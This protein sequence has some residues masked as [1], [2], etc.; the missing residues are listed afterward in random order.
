[1][2]VHRLRFVP[3]NVEAIN[4]LAFSENGKLA[5]SRADGSLELWNPMKNW[6]QEV[7]IRADKNSSIESL[8]WYENRL[9]TAGLNGLIQEWD[10][11]KQK[12]ISV[13]ESFGIPVWCLAVDHVQGLLAA[14][15]ED[16]SVKLYSV[17]NGG[18]T[19]V[20]TLSKQEGR[21]MSIAWSKSG[22]Y[23]ATGGADSTI[24]RY[25]LKSGSCE[26]RITLDEHQHSKDTVVWDLKCL[27]DNCIV[28]AL[29]TG[30]LQIYDGKLGTLKQSFELCAADILTVA[31]SANEKTLFASGIDQK[32]VK[33][34][35]VSA[36]KQFAVSE[37]ALVHTHDVRALAISS[38]GQLV[39]GGI[40][41]QL[42][43]Y[44]QE[45][46]GVKKFATIYPP[47]SQHH[48]HYQLVKNILI[49]QQPRYL[50]FWKLQEVPESID[51]KFSPCHPT[52]HYLLQL[53]TTDDHV[54]C[55]TVS[56]N[57]KLCA[58]ATIS[59]VWIYELFL[60]NA[61]VVS[62][63]RLDYKACKMTFVFQDK[64]I[65]CSMEGTIDIAEGSGY[66]EWSC[67]MKGTKC[68]LPYLISTS[69]DG[70]RVALTYTNQS[71]F[72]I[73]PNEN[74]PIKNIPKLPSVVTAIDF[75]NNNI[76]LCCASHEI[77]SYD[78]L[79]DQLRQ[80]INTNASSPLR[81]PIIGIF[82]TRTPKS[83][84]VLYSHYNI[85][86]V[87][88]QIFQQVKPSKT[89]TKRKLEVQ[90]QFSSF[91]WADLS[92]HSPIK[93]DH[94]LYA[95]VMETEGDL[96]VVEKPWEDIL[97]SLPPAL[98]RHKYGVS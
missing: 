95:S 93:C 55:F 85:I 58:V 54:R 4:C 24:R 12:P 60:D 82:F 27:S 7:V 94:V 63:T 86:L 10:T 72:V 11:N 98:A 9:F 81:G 6:L 83:M 32:V 3:H 97:S 70:N 43:L 51:T 91:S 84:M 75:V 21:V 67:V 88:Y 19:Y 73:C 62:L 96:C 20:N 45:H 69:H 37:S 30:K 14:G 8:L 44:N 41:T 57:A 52:P 40:D 25:R 48:Q 68:E 13:N 35:W 18:I 26:L 64:L 59:A 33:L 79:N 50:Q 80:W 49:V 56:S 74:K 23:I 87:D 92:V 17:C 16:G 78:L 22:K 65:L 42:V 66:S 34:E 71:G 53:N 15:C 39:S 76:V 38:S 61:K 89:G 1:M 47:F 36:G 28:S 29:S 90:S 46:F 31:V 2:N 77:F 5:L